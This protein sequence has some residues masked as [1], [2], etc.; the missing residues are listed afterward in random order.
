MKTLR[1]PTKCD[2]LLN[3]FDEV[4]DRRPVK[5]VLEMTGIVNYNALKALLSYIRKAKHIPDEHR[6]D[7]RI[8]DEVCVRIG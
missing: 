3:L 8:K 1:R 2:T 5:D 7:V 6:I 4:G